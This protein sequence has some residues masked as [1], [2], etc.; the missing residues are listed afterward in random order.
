MSS[1]SKSPQSSGCWSGTSSTSTSSSPSRST[2][3]VPPAKWGVDDKALLVGDVGDV[4]S[5]LRGTF[6]GCS[7][8]S[9]FIRFEGDSSSWGT[10]PAFAISFISSSTMSEGSPCRRSGWGSPW[11][12]RGCTSWTGCWGSSGWRS[13]PEDSGT[14]PSRR[15]GRYSSSL[16]INNLRVLLRPLLLSFWH[17][18]P[19]CELLHL[20]SLLEVQLLQ[21][22]VSLFSSKSL[23]PL[24][25]F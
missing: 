8:N 9:F 25:T 3:W 1:S 11:C 20:G 5:P 19:R 7:S 16:S 12:S 10:P 2:S 23:K 6:E 14:P 24:Q 4:G 21:V 18:P 15:S 13:C 22:L 17:R